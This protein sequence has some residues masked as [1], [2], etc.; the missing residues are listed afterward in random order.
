MAAC[1]LNAA[2]TQNPL[3]T[4][5]RTPAPPYSNALS[6]RGADAGQS[7]PWMSGP[8][9]PNPTLLSAGEPLKTVACSPCGADSTPDCN[10]PRSFPC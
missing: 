3:L 4:T 10:I 8:W 5:L 6:S 7:P 2:L 9:S 1:C